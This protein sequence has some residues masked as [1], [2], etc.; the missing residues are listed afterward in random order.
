VPVQLKMLADHV[1][2]MPNVVR[3]SKILVLKVV[4]KN[5]QLNYQKE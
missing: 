4:I 5:A 3:F 2:L 1:K